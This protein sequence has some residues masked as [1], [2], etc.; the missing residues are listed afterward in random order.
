MLSR[1]SYGE[2]GRLQPLGPAAPAA[3]PDVPAVAFN[4]LCVNVRLS[5]VPEKNGDCYFGKGLAYRG[6]YSLTTSGASCL[7]WSSRA[8]IGKVYTA[9]KNNA[10]A[11]GLGKHNYCRYVAQGPWVPIWAGGRSGRWDERF[12]A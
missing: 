2:P 3:N 1:P 6:T 7:Q 12:H 4:W 5:F 9:W 8:L 11:L 10:Q